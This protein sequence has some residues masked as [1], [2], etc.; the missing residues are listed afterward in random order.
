MTD[1]IDKKEETFVDVRIYGI[2][3]EDF[4]YFMEIVKSFQGDRVTAFKYLLDSYSKELGLG[5]IMTRLQI[6]ENRLF[7][8]ENKERKD[9]LKTFGSD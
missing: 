6:I 1:G 8:L 7:N 5:P 2:P 4:D 3:K 9:E